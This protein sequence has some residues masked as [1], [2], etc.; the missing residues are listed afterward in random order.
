LRKCFLW[1]TFYLYPAMKSK[2]TLKNISELLHISISTVSRALNDHPDIADQTK[3]KVR[4]LAEMLDYEPNAFAIYLRTNASKLIGLI[5][6]EISNF[7]YHSFI[8][9]VEEEARLKGYS[10]MILQSANKKDTEL[11]NLKLCKLNRVAGIMVA[12]STGTNDFSAF[13]RVE[14]S[15]IPLVFFD[16]V[17]EEQGFMTV[18][19]DD[20]IAGKLAAEAIILKKRKKVLA[21]FGNPTLSITRKRLK[22][23]SAEFK[24]TSPKTKIMFAHADNSENA[25]TLTLSALKKEAP[26]DTVFC[27]SD[28][29]LTGSIKAIQQHKLSFPRDISIIAIS[30]GFIPSLFNPEITYVETSGA[31]LGKKALECMLDRL[32]H[33]AEPKE[34][35]IPA[36]L[37]E[38]ESI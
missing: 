25:R 15:G 16:K 4:E 1:K 21:I 13:R 24:K 12:L 8:A 27:M 18:C 31:K 29:I 22:T 38:G 11:A 19:V 26:P 9:S 6:P 33:D 34:I 2:A 5:V 37:V 30:N 20:D 36:R 23:F 32:L 17:P 10:L 3:K 35:I 7:F 28:E 14:E